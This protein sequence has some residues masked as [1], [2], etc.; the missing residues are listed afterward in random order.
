M[1]E[2]QTNNTKERHRPTQVRPRESGEETVWVV[3]FDVKLRLQSAQDPALRGPAAPSLL[4]LQ[5]LAVTGESL[6][7]ALEKIG[8]LGDMTELPVGIRVSELSRSIECLGRL[9]AAL[10]AATQ[11]HLDFLDDLTA[12]R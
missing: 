4:A 5:E 2:K 6:F 12:D 1:S 7:W 8:A 3:A 9:G 10:M 11:P